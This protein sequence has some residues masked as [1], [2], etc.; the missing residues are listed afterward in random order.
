MPGTY[1][2]PA[3]NPA[4]SPAW[5]QGLPPGS[6]QSCRYRARRS[7]VALAAAR[8][9][10]WW[11]VRQADPA[12]LAP[13]PCPLAPTAGSSWFLPSGGRSRS[14]E[15]RTTVR[16]PQRGH[17]KELARALRADLRLIGVRLADGSDARF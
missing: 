11:S 13:L 8:A 1:P 17:E 12:A 15:K 3:G 5:T 6:K 9:N 2:L 16:Q 10:G 4:S 14:R 7:L